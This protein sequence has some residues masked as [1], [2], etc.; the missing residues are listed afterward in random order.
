MGLGDH[1]IMCIIY[2]L[3]AILIYGFLIALIVSAFS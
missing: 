2:A 3:C 1:I